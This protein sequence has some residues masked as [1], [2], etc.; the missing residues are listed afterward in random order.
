MSTMDACT[1][2]FRVDLLMGPDRFEPA[3]I[4]AVSNSSPVCGVIL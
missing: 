3:G 2:W 4:A 1:C